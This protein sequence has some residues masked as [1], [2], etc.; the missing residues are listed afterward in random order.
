MSFGGIGP[1]LQYGMGGRTSHVTTAIW[2][3]DETGKRELYIVESRD[4]SDWPHSGIQCNTYDLWISMITK[5]EQSV[6]YLP[7]KKEY[8]EKYDATKAWA[9]FKELEGTA[10]GY[11]NV[12]T[13]W[14]GIFSITK[15]K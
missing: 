2:G 7:L 9:R 1:I 4:G 10:Y 15:T 13:G 14:I 5:E 6:V 11:P 12:I 8:S 3:N